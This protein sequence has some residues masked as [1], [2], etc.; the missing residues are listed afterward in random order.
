MSQIPDSFDQMGVSSMEDMT[1]SE[2]FRKGQLVFVG[3]DCNDIASTGS[4]CAKLSGQAHSA[5]PH[6]GNGRAE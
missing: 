1:S 3:I 4:Q 5:H 6:N 2:L